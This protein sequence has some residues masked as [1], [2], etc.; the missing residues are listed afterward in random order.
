M[1]CS[2]VATCRQ[3]A[4]KMYKNI[5]FPI[6]YKNI[7]FPIQ[8]WKISVI[9]LCLLEQLCHHSN[10]NLR[11]FRS[12][13]FC[14][15]MDSVCVYIYVCVKHVKVNLV[16][17]GVEQIHQRG[18]DDSTILMASTNLYKKVLQKEYP[19]DP[20]HWCPESN[21]TTRKLEKDHQ[22]KYEIGR[23]RWMGLPKPFDVRF[24]CPLEMGLPKKKAELHRR[25][26]GIFVAMSL[27]S[28]TEQCSIT[29]HTS[30]SIY[31]ETPVMVCRKFY[32][33]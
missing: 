11:S 13:L 17:T 18:S 22:T 2:L 25:S 5:D 28:I 8:N 23:R 6:Q 26:Y 31:L 16:Q 32:S 20:S 1:V 19:E 14:T 24:M 3:S 21:N 30:L 10:R 15:A 27:A 33:F 12:V 29:S 9:F 7:D 4:Y